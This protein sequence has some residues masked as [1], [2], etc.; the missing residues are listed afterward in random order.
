MRA[1]LL[2]AALTG[3]PTV[4]GP[5]EADAPTCAACEA[6]NV[7]A[8]LCFDAG[9]GV[10]SQG[11]VLPVDGGYIARDGGPFVSCPGY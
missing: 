5:T 4:C 1:L 6:P 7:C 9:L 8:T 2:A 10:E 3:L 11:C